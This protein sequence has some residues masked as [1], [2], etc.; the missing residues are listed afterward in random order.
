MSYSNAASLPTLKLYDA[1]SHTIVYNPADPKI[2]WRS[3]LTDM[4]LPLTSIF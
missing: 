2:T 1:S 3:N 4:D